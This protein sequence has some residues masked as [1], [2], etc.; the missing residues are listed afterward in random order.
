MDKREQTKIRQQRYRDKQKAL[1]HYVTPVTESVTLTTSECLARTIENRDRE[2]VVALS[3]IKP[4]S[5]LPDYYNEETQEV[6]K[7]QYGQFV[8]ACNEADVLPDATEPTLGAVKEGLGRKVKCTESAVVTLKG[9]PRVRYHYS[10]DS[11]PIS[12]AIRCSTI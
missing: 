4:P 12:M 9:P 3:P 8:K 1:R 5:E 10:K 6:L 2:F 11:S 7:G